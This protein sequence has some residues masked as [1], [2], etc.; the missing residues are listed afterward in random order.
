MGGVSERDR[1][2]T[3]YRADAWDRALAA[4]GLTSKHP[5]LT[6]NMRYGF[7]I[8]DMAPVLETFTPP[9]HPPATEHMDFITDYISEQVRLGRMTG[10]YSKDRVEEILGAPFISSPLSVIPKA[11]GKL[12]LIQDCSHEDEYGM[13]VNARIDADLFPTE[14]GTAAKMAEFVSLISFAQKHSGTVFAR[15]RSG[16]MR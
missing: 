9:N 2:I 1:I 11:G 3:P 12:R 7:E 5:N 15:D 4:L 16:G 14:W 8:G 13:S 6:H 10:P